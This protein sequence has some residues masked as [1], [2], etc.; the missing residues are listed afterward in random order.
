MNNTE[1]VPVIL[2]SN[3]IIICLDQAADVLISIS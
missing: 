1:Q 2:K 3:N